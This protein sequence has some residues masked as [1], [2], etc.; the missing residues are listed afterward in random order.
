MTNQINQCFWYKTYYY[1][2][3]NLSVGVVESEKPTDPTFSI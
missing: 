3:N 1:M 2:A